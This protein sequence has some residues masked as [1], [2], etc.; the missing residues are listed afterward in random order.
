[1]ILVML[2]P[3]KATYELIMTEQMT[4]IACKLIL[5]SISKAL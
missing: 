1:M 4:D 3:Q 2:N 5:T